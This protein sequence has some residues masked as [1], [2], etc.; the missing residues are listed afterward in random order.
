MLDMK[1]GHLCWDVWVR[2][3]GFYTCYG[4]GREEQVMGGAPCCGEICGVW[5]QW[6]GM[7]CWVPLKMKCE[8]RN[9]ISGML[10]L[11]ETSWG[12]K[13]E[14]CWIFYKC[15]AVTSCKEGLRLEMKLW[16]V[17]LLGTSQNNLK[18]FSCGV[19]VGGRIAWVVR[20]QHEIPL[21]LDATLVAKPKCLKT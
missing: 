7:W 17:T 8:S 5:R 21:G 19:G 4:I 13:Q 9:M 1:R 20:I 16:L 2:W 14:L 18:R 12:W 15:V 3:W 6:S 10:S 11:L